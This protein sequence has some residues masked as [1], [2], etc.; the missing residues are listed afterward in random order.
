MTRTLLRR[1]ALV[2]VAPLIVGC[3]SDPARTEGGCN[4][5]VAW[6]KV[7]FRPHNELNQAAPR[8]EPLGTG[9]VLDC[10][11]KFNPSL[12]T[13][14]VFAIDG[15]D[16]SL[17]IRTGNDEWQGVYVAEGVPQSSWPPVLRVR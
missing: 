10:D 17:A 9:D 4:A 6:D 13:V 12:G 11:G 7:V 8:G 15:V 2:I 1:L 16:P 5:R 3:A 14:K